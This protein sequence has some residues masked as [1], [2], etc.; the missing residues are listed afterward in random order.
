[1]SKST[2]LSEL[3]S[4]SETQPLVHDILKEIQQESTASPVEVQAPEVIAM[5]P[6]ESGGQMVDANPEEIYQQQQED[7]VQYQMDP[8]LQNPEVQ[9]DTIPEQVMGAPLVVPTAEQEFQQP[10]TMGQRI[11]SEIKLPLLVA[12]LTILI[13][14][15]AFSNLL[16]TGLAKIPGGSN[17]IVPIIVKSLLVA[18]LFYVGNKII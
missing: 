7:N 12:V 18:T 13:S 6:M 2:P 8:N 15:P 9:P 16:G 11:F 10:T 14:V 4:T 5:P 1:M 17:A 3:N